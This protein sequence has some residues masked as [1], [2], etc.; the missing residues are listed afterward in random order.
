M[1]EEAEEGEPDESGRTSEKRILQRETRMK[2]MMG[3]KRTMPIRAVMMTTTPKDR[4]HPKTKTR[5][6]GRTLWTRK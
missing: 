5:K 3:R 4:G 6:E 1:D 2:A